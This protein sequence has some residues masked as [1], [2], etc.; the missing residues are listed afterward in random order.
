MLLGLVTGSAIGTA[1]GLLHV[2][3]HATYQAA[4][5]MSVLAVVHR[6][7][8]ADLNQLGGLVARMPLSFLVM[9]FGIIGLAGLP[10]MNGFVSK[11]MIYRAL[12]TDGMPLLFVA[13]IVGTLGTILSVYKLIHNMFLGQLRIEH[14]QVRE[15][16][17]SMLVP[18]SRW[19]P[20]SS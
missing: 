1:G 8:T 16:P 14:E 3:N 4:L 13:A 6:T 20:S 19:P 2:F 18:C 15:A 11:W 9:L 7:G 12:I 17:L 10:P 5:F